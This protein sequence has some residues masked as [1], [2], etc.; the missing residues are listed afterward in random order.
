M[1]KTKAEEMENSFSKS[2]LCPFLQN[3]LEE[4]EKQNKILITMQFKANLLDLQAKV[5]IRL[6]TVRSRSS[7]KNESESFYFD[8][9]VALAFLGDRFFFGDLAFLGLLGLRA[10]FGFLAFFGDPAFLGFFDFDT[11]F[12]FFGASAAAAA[13]SPPAAAGLALV[14]F[15]AAFLARGFFA[16]LAFLATRAGFFSPMRNEPEAP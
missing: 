16:T 8:A 9:L 7:R 2:S 10:T 3:F 1:E 5:C 11:R 13:P 6:L 12:F 14:D 15:L 4:E